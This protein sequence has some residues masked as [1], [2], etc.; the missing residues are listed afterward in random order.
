M[1]RLAS[2]H[3]KVALALLSAG[4]FGACVVKDVQLVDRL[5]GDAGAGGSGGN[6]SDAG[7]PSGAGK[8]SSADG[9]EDATAGEGSGATQS[10]AGT[11]SGGNGG[12][13]PG[14][15]GGASPGGSA[16]TNQGGTNNPVMIP[17]LQSCPDASYFVCDNFETGASDGWQSGPVPKEVADAPSGEHVLALAFVPERLQLMF[18]AV[19]VSFWVRLDTVSDQP[20]LS[21][22]SGNQDKVQLGLEESRFRWTFWSAASQSTGAVRVPQNNADSRLLP[23]GF[24]FCVEMSVQVTPQRLDARVVIPGATPFVMPTVDADP[25]PGVDEQ[26]NMSYPWAVNGNAGFGFGIDGAYQ[27]IDDVMIGAFDQKTLC[28]L[29]EESL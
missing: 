28:E 22:F 8:T 20:F 29:Y 13:T 5:P 6:T 27:E 26:W 18:Q 10:T 11:D 15:S 1:A 9:G 3:R 12:T 2:H 7:S 23:I 21:F 14:G 17:D 19:K 24:W 4:L 16:G 25:T